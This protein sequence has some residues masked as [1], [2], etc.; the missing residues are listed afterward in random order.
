[1]AE[2]KKQKRGIDKALRKVEQELII[3]FENAGVDCMEVDLGMLIRIKNGD[4]YDWRIE[5]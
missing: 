5:I 4:S 2:L 3:V 1:M